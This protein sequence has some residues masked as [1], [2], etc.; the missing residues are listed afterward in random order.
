MEGNNNFKKVICG[1]FSLDGGVREDFFGG[2]NMW[3]EFC[4]VNVLD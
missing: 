2:C 3:V 1:G 4:G